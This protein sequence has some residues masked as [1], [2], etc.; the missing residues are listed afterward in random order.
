MLR[1]YSSATG[2]AAGGAAPQATRPF[3]AVH[4]FIS[5]ALVMLIVIVGGLT[6]LTESGLSITEWN[7]GLKG[8]RLPRTDAEWEAEWAKYRETPEFQLL[9]H[10]MT[11]DEF[12]TIFM[13]EW[14]HRML[15]RLLGG[16][17]LIPAAVYCLK[18]GWTTPDV[19]YKVLA[20][21]V[22]IGLQG[23]MGW[24][25]VASG[26]QDPYANDPS[27]PDSRPEW[28]PRVSHFRLAA[29]LGLA[30]AM[31]MGMIYTGVGIL[32]DAFYARK[33]ATEGMSS[34][35][36][37]VETLLKQ[38]QAPRAKRVF[39]GG[40]ALT[41][42][43]FTTAIW[44]AFVAGLDA[45]LIYNEFPFMGDRRLLPPSEEMFNKR[46]A[47]RKISH[48]SQEASLRPVEPEKPTDMALY[49]GNILQNP[50][51]VQA[52][53]RYLGLTSLA[54]L[55]VYGVRTK[56]LKAVLPNATPRFATGAMHMGILQVLLGI[57]T[58][59]HMVPIPVASAHQIG[60]LIILTMMSG[61]LAS[62]RRPAHAIRTFSRAYAQAAPKAPQP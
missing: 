52:L 53:H 43:V 25:M 35:A 40:V 23:L 61:V 8:M 5:A 29:H 47:L 18:P 30:F 32:R 4:M 22:G 9:N 39:A 12:K 58:L 54:A 6:R 55:I 14:A 36:A 20:L 28:Q 59:V 16:V 44:G 46:Y 38:L 19:R 26:L 15:G 57:A 17:F 45:G 13:W 60:S 56:K 27:S 37:A 21:A 3:V 7:P 48:D 11:V 1:A 42:L 62:L 41:A 2:A 50:A 34:G 10:N 51:T 24:V 33:F 49:T 31:Y